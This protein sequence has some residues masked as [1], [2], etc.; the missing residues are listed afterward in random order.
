M[1]SDLMDWILGATILKIRNEIGGLNEDLPIITVTKCRLW[2]D[3]VR[4]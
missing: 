4:L 2:T 1:H 3:L